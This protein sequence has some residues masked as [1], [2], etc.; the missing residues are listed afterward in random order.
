MHPYS[1]AQIAAICSEVVQQLAVL[2]DDDNA[3]VVSDADTS[4]RTEEIELRRTEEIELIRKNLLF[5]LHHIH[6][7]SQPTEHNIAMRKNE[8]AME[9]W[10]TINRQVKSLVTELAELE[11]V[12]YDEI[13][14]QIRR[15]G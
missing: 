12:P 14:D 3:S 10:N 6:R 7:L 13:A 11:G 5:A 9:I 15:P 2:Q 4:V 1:Q 8:G